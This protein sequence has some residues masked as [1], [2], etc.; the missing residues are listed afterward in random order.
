MMFSYFKK[1]VG[2]FLC[3]GGAL[4][5]WQSGVLSEFVKQGINFDAVA[6][7]SIGALNGA[8]YCYG[9]TSELKKIW[10]EMNPSILR[11]SPRYNRMPLDIY[12]Q[13]GADPLSKI[14][15]Y[16]KNNL[17]KFTLFSEKPVYDF[18]N[19]WLVRSGPK[20]KK[21]VKFYVI[22]HIVELKLPHVSV[23]DGNSKSDKLPFIDSLVASCSIPMVFPPVPFEENG[24]KYNLVDGGVIGIASINLNILEGCK[25]I[26]MICNSRAEDLNYKSHNIAGPLVDNIHRMLA[27]HTQKIYESRAFISSAPQVYLMR[28]PVDLKMSSLD[29]VGKKCAA[30]F[31]IGENEAKIFL[32]NFNGKEGDKK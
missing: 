20:F 5:A 4:G 23:F 19:G 6:G 28:P 2:L 30:A 26:I 13:V 11:F 32:K 29:F 22:S 25:T 18:L 1:P 16:I 15:F 8:A 21:N 14:G 12:R 24:K 3:G 9:K 17:A 27:L 7:F 31:S 10:T